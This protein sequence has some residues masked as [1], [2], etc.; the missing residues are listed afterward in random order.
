MYE[1]GFILQSLNFVKEGLSAS[2]PEVVLVGD[3]TQEPP[4][5]QGDIWK[6]GSCI[7][8]SSL[9]ASMLDLS[10]QVVSG[11][12]A[13]ELAHRINFANTLDAGLRL[14]K[15]AAA[16][17]IHVAEDLTLIKGPWRKKSASVKQRMTESKC[18]PVMV[19][20]RDRGE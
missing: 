18:E 20:R 6:S 19:L 1:A 5:R 10:I 3:P 8:S 16:F 4:H 13:Q 17:V 14:D 7:S 15:F 9:A 12:L 11:L 2:G